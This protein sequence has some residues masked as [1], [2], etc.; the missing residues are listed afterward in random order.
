MS[1]THAYHTMLLWPWFVTEG[2]AGLSFCSHCALSIDE[3]DELNH[4]ISEN[5]QFKVVKTHTGVEQQVGTRLAITFDNWTIY[6]Q[7]LLV[8]GQS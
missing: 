3:V 7:I 4:K 1:I 6:G 5:R 2:T 8:D